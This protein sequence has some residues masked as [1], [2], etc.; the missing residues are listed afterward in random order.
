MGTFSMKL[1]K[2]H[3]ILA[4]VWRD[5]KEIILRKLKTKK[6]FALLQRTFYK[7]CIRQRTRKGGWMMA[8]EMVLMYAICK[9]WNNNIQEDRR[10]STLHLVWSIRIIVQKNVKIWNT[11]E[12]I[13]NIFPDS[14]C[15]LHIF[16][17][18]LISNVFKYVVVC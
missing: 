2:G 12:H 6:F 11:T 9:F 18:E 10:V 1:F 13:Q 7:V 8:V 14:L 4:K 15:L 3:L 17:L 16:Y 5:Y